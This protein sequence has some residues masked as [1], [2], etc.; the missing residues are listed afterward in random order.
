[1]GNF[2]EQYLTLAF[3]YAEA[4]EKAFE[5]RPVIKKA[6]NENVKKAN[7]IQKKIYGICKIAKEKG[8][9]Q[10]ITEYMHHPNKYIQCI[11]AAYYFFIDTQTA[12]SVLQ[13]LDQLPPPNAV[14]MKAFTILH[15]YE[16]GV[17]DNGLK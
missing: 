8:K 14:G 13:E 2:K 11:T 6:L 16:L 4:N 1:M 5:T 9:L 7:S 15:A 3:E 12:L 10:E 17:Y